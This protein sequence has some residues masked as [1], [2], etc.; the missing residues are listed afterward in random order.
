MPSRRGSTGS[1][2]I[3]SARWSSLASARGNW[4]HET[5]PFGLTAREL[6]VVNLVGEGCMNR[7]IGARMHI[8]EHTVKHHLSRVFD[9]TG[10][11]SRVE[12][13]LFAH[14]HSLTP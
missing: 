6:Q 2:P 14:H 8:S 1:D 3:P 7:E 11:S 12:L 5:R 13:A 10:T 4:K 9:K